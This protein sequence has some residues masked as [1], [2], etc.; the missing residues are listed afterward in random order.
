MSTNAAGK[1]SKGSFIV[2]VGD[3]TIV[4]LLV[5]FNLPLMTSAWKARLSLI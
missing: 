3:K 1:P 5:R 4:S 2:R